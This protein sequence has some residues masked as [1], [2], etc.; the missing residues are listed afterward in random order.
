MW[1]HAREVQTQPVPR[2]I[3]NKMGPAHRSL[4]CG[5]G[6]K[7]RGVCGATVARREP[8]AGG[9]GRRVRAGSPQRR[10]R[11]E[12]CDCIAS[13]GSPR[14]LP[15][16]RETKTETLRARCEHLVS[17]G[18]RQCGYHRFESR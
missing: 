18:I 17:C 6:R 11:S 12:G 9:R 5:R 1:K 3:N 13:R 16:I 14:T 7:A 4:A 10:Y 2:P 15:A 8:V